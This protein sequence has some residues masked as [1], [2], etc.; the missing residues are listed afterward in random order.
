MKCPGQDSRY[1]K[2]G[3]IFEAKC[4]E[5]GNDVEFFKDDAARVCK[6]CGHR[7][8]NPAM[9][10]GCASYCK[11]AEQC[12]GSVSPE[13][14]A[15]REDLLKDR[16]A[17]EMKR[18]LKQDFRRIGHAIRTARYAEEIAK[19]EGGDLAVILTVAY[20]H[21]LGA[22]VAREILAKLGARDELIQEVCDL[23]DGE[24]DPGSGDS[25]NLNA[26]NEA[27]FIASLEERD[28]EASLSREELTEILKKS[29]LT[30][31]GHRLAKEIL[32]QSLSA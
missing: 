22:G 10:F 18:H 24:H 16:V 27:E 4:P 32:S 13:L 2:P 19:E 15:Q 30:D 8:L 5:C 1:W 6:K 14:L 25:L 3:A 21:N 20:L 23:I 29:S 11:Y 17:V 28:K 12:L 31:T 9:D 7:F 26:V